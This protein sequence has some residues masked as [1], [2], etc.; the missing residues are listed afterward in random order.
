MGLHSTVGLLVLTLAV[1]RIL[2]RSTTPAPAHVGP[3]WLAPLANA[4][5]VALYALTVA[6]P[7]TGL[8]AR[9]AHSGTATLIG[10]LSIPAPFPLPQTKLFGEV[11]VAI[12]YTLAA[13]VA[14]HVLAALVHHFVLRDATLRRMAPGLSR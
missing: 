1:L 13:L 3:A 5:H 4:G 9:W 12:A 6:L 11:H 2:W 10:G 14:A 7:V 8:V